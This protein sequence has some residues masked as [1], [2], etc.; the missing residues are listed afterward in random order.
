MRFMFLLIFLSKPNYNLRFP[1]IAEII[2]VKQ[3]E[4]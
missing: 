4:M 1:N 2:S 3:L